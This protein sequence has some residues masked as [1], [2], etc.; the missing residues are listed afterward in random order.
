ML[1]SAASRPGAGGQAETRGFSRTLLG[2]MGLEHSPDGRPVPRL[3]ARFPW[4]P[5]LQAGSEATAAAV[6]PPACHHQQ[7]SH[8]P[9]TG[10]QRSLPGNS[11]TAPLRGKQLGGGRRGGST[12]WTPQPEWSGA[13]LHGEGADLG[14]YVRSLKETG[15][16]V[17][18]PSGL[19]Y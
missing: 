12:C 2:E 11:T 16:L 14:R 4:D 9:G 7:E 13:R 18:A 5:G 15:F 19:E 10:R 8:S 17:A 3:L 1:G 6:F